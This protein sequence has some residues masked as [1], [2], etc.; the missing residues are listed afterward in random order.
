MKTEQI[1]EFIEMGEDV[2]VDQV[3][4]DCVQDALLYED[5]Y[6]VESLDKYMEM[7]ETDKVDEVFEEHLSKVLVPYFAESAEF[8]EGVIFEG[9]S[10]QVPRSYN[11][12]KKV[13]IKDKI[14]TGTKNA[15]AFLKTMR[16]KYGAKALAGKIGSA[17]QAAKTFVGDKATK[18][19]QGVSAGIA[20]LR[21]K[22]PATPAAAAA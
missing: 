9:K 12:K 15:G 20:A 1:F 7:L 14:K 10:F 19:R 16:S 22:K 18:L 8:Y 21:G 2:M 4:N 11:I 5:D 6:I 17:Y 13:G 3:F